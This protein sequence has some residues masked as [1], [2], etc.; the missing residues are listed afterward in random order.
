VAADAGSTIL[1]SEFADP[2][3]A[4][5]GYWDEV[6]ES[7]LKAEAL[8]AAAGANDQRTQ[9]AGDAS[10]LAQSRCWSGP[11]D[12]WGFA[13]RGRAFAAAATRESDEALG[14]VH[15]AAKDI[16][17]SGATGDVPVSIINGGETDL[18]VTFKS[19]SNDLTVERKE[20]EIV[21]LRPSE[22]LYSVPV[23][24]NTALAGTLRIEVWADELLLDEH[25]VRVSA[26]YLDRLAII[27]GVAIV[28]I[29]MLVFIRRRV[30]RASAGTI[31]EES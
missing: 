18:A 25:E 11:D 12:S 2:G 31:D 21:T 19:T 15:I 9:A 6:A 14:V 24:L 30:T 1:R 7:R 8:L 20:V 29:G 3:D 4:P 27:G 22:N 28:L 23:D 26:S 17:L 16:T 10:M 13:D 5:R